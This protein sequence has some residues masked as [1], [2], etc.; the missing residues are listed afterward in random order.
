MLFNG[1]DFETELF[2]FFDQ[3][4]DR[5]LNLLTNCFLLLDLF[6][7]LVTSLMAVSQMFQLLS[8][9]FEGYLVSPI[10]AA[11]EFQVISLIFLRMI[12]A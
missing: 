3:D 1:F 6:A 5:E 7:V 9:F 12:E 2:L 4:F 11:Q 8:D 10:A